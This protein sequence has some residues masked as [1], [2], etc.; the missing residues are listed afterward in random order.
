MSAVK[1]FRVIIN[2]CQWFNDHRHRARIFINDNIKTIGDLKKRIE[3]IFQIRDFHLSSRNEYLPSSED[4]RIL[5]NDDVVWV[6]QNNVPKTTTVVV[7]NSENIIKNKKRS[8]SIIEDYTEQDAPPAKK[9]KKKK[10]NQE[11]SPDVKHPYSP[12]EEPK[13]KKKHKRNGNCT[14][15][16]DVFA[17]TEDVTHKVKKMKK[18]VTSTS[19]NYTTPNTLEDSCTENESSSVNINKLIPVLQSHINSP[20][21]KIS[22]KTESMSVS[23][24]TSLSVPTTRNLQS[25]L[26][27]DGKEP[28]KCKGALSSYK[29]KVSVPTITDKYL[30][31]KKVNIVKIEYLLGGPPHVKEVE[32]TTNNGAAEHKSYSR[33]CYSSGNIDNGIDQNSTV[34][35][36]EVRSSSEIEVSATDNNICSPASENE[37][38]KFIPNYDKNDISYTIMSNSLISSEG[39]T[40]KCINESQALQIKDK[41]L[42]NSIGEKEVTIPDSEVKKPLLTNSIES[43][44]FKQASG[45]S[46]QHTPINNKDSKLREAI[47]STFHKPKT[48][49]SLCDVLK[50]D[51]YRTSEIKQGPSLNKSVIPLIKIDLSS[52]EK[53]KNPRETV[54]ESINYPELHSSLDKDVRSSLNNIECEVD[55][56]YLEKIDSDVSFSNK[57]VN[58]LIENSTKELQQINASDLNNFVNKTDVFEENICTVSQ[59]ESPNIQNILNEVVN[60]SDNSKQSDIDLTEDVLRSSPDTSILS[61]GSSSTFSRR[62]QLSG[63]GELLGELRNSE[64]LITGE[65]MDS[66]HSEFVTKRKR[67]RIRK[68]KKK[69][70]AVNNTSLNDSSTVEDSHIVPK[71]IRSKACPTLH[72]KFEEED[73]GHLKVVDLTGKENQNAENTETGMETFTTEN[74]SLDS[75]ASGNFSIEEEYILKSPS[76]KKILPKVGDI[77]AFKILRI[78]ENYTPEVSSYI[79]GKVT[80]FNNDS[81]VVLYEILNGLEHC[82]DPEGILSLEGTDEIE[83]SNKREFAWADIIDPRLLFP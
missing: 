2:L 77:I 62:K 49:T 44:S 80:E 83:D 24:E 27:E 48:H 46:S 3:N 7:S 14:E 8:I 23:L 79:I 68:R 17:Q 26:H 4:V 1:N 39:E 69:N 45:K 82:K 64:S 47:N 41:S 78:T 29:K 12:E 57:S 36:P 28:Y 55:T 25:E 81:K 40:E 21:K 30:Q 18:M 6:V 72:L 33:C 61:R 58:N 67:K 51:T 66:D 74:I 56:K 31:E 15:Q 52:E 9:K 50:K 35:T 22:N 73:G 43:L 75:D 34:L 20:K 13:K 53:N 42:N 16:K 71:P 32:L 76:I 5:Q 37:N 59:T 65:S 19:N 38:V 54:P 63:I 70:N 10:H 60:L 11:K